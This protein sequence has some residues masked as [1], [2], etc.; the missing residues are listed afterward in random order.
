MHVFG[1][2][3]AVMWVASIVG[4]VANIVQITGMVIEPLTALFILKCIGVFV[5]PLGS[6]L[7]IVGMF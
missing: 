4:W 2:F 3:F 5:A 1:L 7:G 6:V